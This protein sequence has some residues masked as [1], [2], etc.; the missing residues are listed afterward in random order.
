MEKN[1]YKGKLLYIA[2]QEMLEDFVQR[3]SS[4]SIL[5]IDTEFLREKTYYARLCLIQLATD[6]EVAIVDPFGVRDLKA[7]VPLF[8]NEKIVKVFHAAKQDLE[9]IYRQ[10]GILPKPIFDTQIAAALLGHTQ[11]IG[12]AALVFAECDVRLRKMESFTDWSRRPLSDSQLSYAEEDVT[13]LP[14]IYRSMRDELKGKGRLK[15][16][17]DDFAQLSD[18][19]RYDE[20]PYECFRH[21]KRVNQLSRRQ[22]AG[23][24]E[25]AAWR[26]LEAQRRDL[27]RKWVV[28]DEQIIEVSK[29]EARSVADLFMIR[30]LKERMDTPAARAVVSRMEAAFD[31]P[32]ESWPDL[33]Q[34]KKNEPNV[35]IEVDLMSALV[36]LRSRESGVAFQTLATHDDLSR[37]A[38]GY[39]KNIDLISGWRRSLVGKELLRLLKG[40]LCLSLEK[41]ELKVTETPRSPDGDG[42]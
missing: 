12:Y 42:E 23:A 37:L 16:L 40:E 6:D 11:Q 1:R 38:R 21:L 27:P 41:G 3:S 5:A 14:G 26:E 31:A 32:P 39:R 19:T 20:D 17:D 24:R 13:Y 30:G 22:L 8:L 33:D 10:T 7:L 2:T 9:I 29:R 25:F 18:P 15:W 4:S 35:D 34:M 28:S 36:R